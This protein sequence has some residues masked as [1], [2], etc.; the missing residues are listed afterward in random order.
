MLKIA[1]V[2]DVLNHGYNLQTIGTAIVFLLSELDEVDRVDVYCPV[3][4]PIKEPAKFPGKI[5]LIPYYNYNDPLLGFKL[6]NIYRGKNYDRVIYNLLATGF[7]ESSLSNASALFSPMLGEALGESVEVIYHNSVYTNDY[8]ALGY[9]SLYDEFRGH[10]LGWV[11]RS[12]FKSV[13]TFF[14]L[15]LYLERVGSAIGANK[16]RYLNGR[17]FEAIPTIFLNNMQE[18]DEITTDYYGNSVKI[19]LHGSWGPQKN[20][21]LGLSTLKRLRDEGFDFDLIISGGINHHFPSYEEQFRSLIQEYGF[22]NSYVGRVSEMGIMNLFLNTDLLLL[23]YNTPGGH[24]GILEQAIF[25]ELPTVGID[26]PEYEEEAS[27]INFVKLC[28]PD[29]FYE[30]TREMLERAGGVRKVKVREK[31]KKAVR[32]I[33]A[34]IDDQ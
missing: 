19:L 11:E 33:T 12:L 2:G 29:G 5:R 22:A 6:L 13:P 25:F 31:V 21:K 32:N 7:G 15:K 24:S 26:F 18:T 3:A 23:P 8:R 16:V 17:G 30:A 1:F 9:S 14:F 28:K 34:L 27:G 20:L 10:I 4:N